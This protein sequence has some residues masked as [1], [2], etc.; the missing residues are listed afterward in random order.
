MQ[1][2]NPLIAAFFA[3][4]RVTARCL[5][6]LAS[7]AL[8][9]VGRRKK[10]TEEFTEALAMLRALRAIVDVDDGGLQQQQQQQPWHVIDLCCGKGFTATLVAVLYPTFRVSAIDRFREEE[11]F[12]PHFAAAGLA[13]VHYERLDVMAAG[14]AEVELARLMAEAGPGRPTVVLGMHLCGL[15]SL[16]AVH[17]LEVLPG[18]RA[19]LL[20]P[21]CLPKRTAREDT[22]AACFAPGIGQ[23]EQ[24]NAWCAFLERK[25]AEA[26]ARS[27]AP[28]RCDHAGGGAATPVVLTGFRGCR[29]EEVDGVISS[30]R[31]VITAG[32]GAAVPLDGALAP[33]PPSAVTPK[34]SRPEANITKHPGVAARSGGA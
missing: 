13:N 9:A 3:E 33:L 18:V 12:L 17:A 22:P 24:Y 30:K 2:P 11:G 14:F 31:T 21:C 15:L 10:F 23:V 34:P 4:P 16:R 7:P 32:R 26:L 8:H 25:A 29:R 27:P 28:A 5:A 19:L 1:P 20:S 6:Q